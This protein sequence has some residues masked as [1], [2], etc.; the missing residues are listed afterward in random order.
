MVR[1]AQTLGLA[2]SPHHEPRGTRLETPHAG[3]TSPQ[4]PSCT[5]AAITK[6]RLKAPFNSR[7][8]SLTTMKR[9]RTE[10]L[11]LNPCCQQTNVVFSIILYVQ[12][13]LG[14]IYSLFYMKVNSMCSIP[15]R[16]AC[17]LQKLCHRTELHGTYI[18]Q[19]HA[20]GDDWIILNIRVSG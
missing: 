6:S 13:C 5:Y 16:K 17:V 3:A 10:F 15:E 11:A 7:R 12:A 2:P 19:T 1:Q 18:I 4:A 20:G 8:C 9:A 14:K